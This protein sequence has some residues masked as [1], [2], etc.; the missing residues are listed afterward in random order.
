MKFADVILPL[1][2]PR[3]YTY[4]IPIELQGMVKP[5]CRVEVQFGSRKVYSG[6]VKKIHDQKPEVYQVKPIRN[7]IDE[8]PIVTETQLTFWAWIASYYMCT[9]GEVMNAA[10]PAHLK[11]VSET[12]IMLNEEANYD[13]SDLDDE[14]FMLIQA[15]ELKKEQGLKKE[16]KT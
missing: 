7:V 8:T 14:E 9:E 3:V 15:L 13:E 2:L 16:K 5:G 1:A 10:L 4:G 11:L 12:C 6:I